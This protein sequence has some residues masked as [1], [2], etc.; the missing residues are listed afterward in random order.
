MVCSRAFKPVSVAAE[1]KRPDES[2]SVMPGFNHCCFVID[3]NYLIRGLCKAKTHLPIIISS[4]GSSV[5]ARFS[6]IFIPSVRAHVWVEHK[7]IMTT[8]SH[9]TANWYLYFL[10]LISFVNSL[11]SSLH[12]ERWKEI[13][14]QSMVQLHGQLKWQKEAKMPLSIRNPQ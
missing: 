4:V 10:Y 6:V 13:C 2:S 14:F 11:N 12:S 1:S 9:V 3:G 7:I 5:L 8:T